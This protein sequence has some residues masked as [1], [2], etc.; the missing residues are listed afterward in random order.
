MRWFTFIVRHHAKG[1]AGVADEIATEMFGV[2][3]TV[4]ATSGKVRA[5]TRWG[6]RRYIRRVFGRRLIE[7]IDLALAKTGVA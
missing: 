6:A 4:Y 2:P 7:I 5:W 3:R 1:F